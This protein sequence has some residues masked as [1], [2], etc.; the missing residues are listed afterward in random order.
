[1]KDPQR[2]GGS[3]LIDI[4]HTDSS[5]S[6]QHL[7][8]AIGQ[9]YGRNNLREVH[10]ADA[11]LAL[12]VLEDPLF[13]ETLAMRFK[14]CIFSNR[15]SVTQRRA[16]VAKKSFTRMIVHSVFPLCGVAELVV[17]DAMKLLEE[18]HKDPMNL[19]VK[20]L[21]LL[22]PNLGPHKL[23]TD[24]EGKEQGNTDVRVCF[25]C[26]DVQYCKDFFTRT[27]R[28][29]SVFDQRLKVIYIHSVPVPMFKRDASLPEIKLQ[30]FSCIPW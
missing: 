3:F 17:Q 6:L 10:F 29:L 7:A 13:L 27:E 21:M 5:V 25:F 26:S 16:R 12:V 9:L 22:H 30:D 19:L 28:R 11:N 2:I 20:G 4:W 23:R 15:S 24:W 18:N 14:S 1:M 8:G